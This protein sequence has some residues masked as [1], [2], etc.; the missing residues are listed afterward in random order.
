MKKRTFFWSFLIIMMTAFASLT[1]VSCGDD[2]EED[3]PNGG[4]GSYVSMLQGTWEFESGTEK[5]AGETVTISRDDL[6]EMKRLMSS[7]V[8]KRVE[9]WDETL[10]FTSSKVNGIKY[11][12]NGSS[13]T[14]EGQPS[15]CSVT[16][17]SLT[18]SKLVLHEE[19]D[20]Q[21]IGKATGVDMSSLV[22]FG[23][24][25]IVADIEYRRK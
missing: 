18:D 7:A 25:N 2:D 22:E 15:G 13:L 6:S 24:S 10:T 12:M 16:V 3:G 14:L 19:L 9:I 23:W 17:A 5:V 21:K 11:K 1:L 8:G 20:F 4:S